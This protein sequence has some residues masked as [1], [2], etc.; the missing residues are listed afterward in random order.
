LANDSTLY[1]LDLSTKQILKSIH[2]STTIEIQEIAFSMSGDTI[3]WVSFVSPISVNHELGL[4]SKYSQTHGH[5]STSGLPVINARSVDGRF[6]LNEQGDFAFTKQLDRLAFT[7]A[8]GVGMYSFLSDSLLFLRSFSSSNSYQGCFVN[9]DSEFVTTTTWDSIAILNAYNGAIVLGHTRPQ[10]DY[11]ISVHPIG[12]DTIALVG[13]DRIFLFNPSTLDTIYSRRSLVDL[14]GAFEWSPHN[15]YF[16]T[17]A[18]VV[19]P[20][21]IGPGPLPAPLIFRYSTHTDFAP[22]LITTVTNNLNSVRFAPTGTE[23]AA[24]SD[25][26]LS[27]LDSNG[28]LLNDLLQWCGNL[29]FNHDATKIGILDYTPMGSSYLGIQIDGST[30]VADPKS[31]AAIEFSKG[32]IGTLMFNSPY[33]EITFSPDDD[34]VAI[35]DSIFTLPFNSS[36]DLW[37]AYT[38]LNSFTPNGSHLFYSYTDIIRVKD[39]ATRQVVDSFPTKHGHINAFHLSHDGTQLLTCGTDGLIRLWKTSDHSLVRTFGGYRASVTGVQFS[40]NE[41]FV[42]S[43]SLD[44]TIRIWDITTGIVVDSF[45][46]FRAPYTDVQVTQD[47]KYILASTPLALVEYGSPKV[48]LES[49]HQTPSSG[50]ALGDAFPNPFSAYSTITFSLPRREFVT[51]KIVNILGET[52]AVTIEGEYDAGPHNTHLDK[53]A[54]HLTSGVYFCELTTPDG[55]VA[56]LMQVE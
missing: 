20:I 22:Q 17:G 15:P 19:E 10:Q 12:R 45:T 1:L 37:P 54:L 7:G 29:T 3:A 25:G 32:S 9:S 53:S 38:C 28:E 2:D 14:A 43:S 16:L 27:L 6:R 33:S 21:V 8:S 34:F 13:S 24:G 48:P 40:P 42:I 35:G 31:L 52:L 23:T 50:F 46:E 44:S 26:C 18:D 41:N 11:L 39:I 51:L 49:V 30:E 36:Y 4:V 47:G 55:S 56:K 5:I